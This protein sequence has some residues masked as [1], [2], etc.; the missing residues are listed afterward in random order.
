MNTTTL[1]IPVH[2]IGDADR[3]DWANRYVMTFQD[4]AFQAPSLGKRIMAVIDSDETDRRIDR[5]M[6]VIV[7]AMVVASVWYGCGTTYGLIMAMLASAILGVF[8]GPFSTKRVG[9]LRFV[10]L[11]R[12]NVSWS[13]S[14][15]YRPF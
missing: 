9:G 3:T 13:V 4:N 12:L 6:S 5:L 2:I 10:K 14:R 15:Q 7:P 11:W 1:D 8:Y